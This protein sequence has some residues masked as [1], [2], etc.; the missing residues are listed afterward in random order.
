MKSWCKLA[1]Q[2]VPFWNTYI[3]LCW[4]SVAD[5]GIIELCFFYNFLASFFFLFKGGKK[6]K[7]TTLCAS[8][9]EYRRK[10]VRF[11]NHKEILQSFNCWG[12]GLCVCIL[13]RRGEQA[14]Y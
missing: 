11:G 6:K 7:E 12:G 10:S 4:D 13:K 1:A 9:E 2:Q 8:V 5:N 14:A 3:C